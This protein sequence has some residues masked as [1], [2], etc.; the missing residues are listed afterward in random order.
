M[1]SRL[2]PV[3]TKVT[4]RDDLGRVRTLEVV[5]DHETVDLTDPNSREFIIFYLEAGLLK[6]MNA[7]KNGGGN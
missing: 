2:E 1:A 3:L 6:K 7:M 4:G 5:Y